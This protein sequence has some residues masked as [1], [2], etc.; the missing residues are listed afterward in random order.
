VDQEASNSR[1]TCRRTRT[2]RRIGL[3]VAL[4]TFAAG[5]CV[6]ACLASNSFSSLQSGQPVVVLTNSQ[7]DFGK[8]DAG[9]RL[10]AHFQVKNTGGRRLI[11]NALSGSCD[12]LAPG[13][14]EVVVPSGASRSLPVILNTERVRGPMRMTLRFATNDPQRPKIQLVVLADIAVSTESD[15]EA[16]LTPIA[17]SGEG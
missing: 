11:L 5:G 7:W 6:V 1:A 4:I 13:K 15:S 9:G 17:A 12:C 14:A 2:V 16:P 8:V 10:S 3:T